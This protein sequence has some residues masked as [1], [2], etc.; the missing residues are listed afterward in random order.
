MTSTPYGCSSQLCVTVANSRKGRGQWRDD[1]VRCAEETCQKVV[2]DSP[3]EG[4][5]SP[6]ARDVEGNELAHDD[7][8]SFGT[9]RR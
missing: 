4:A 8:E 5:G 2:L 1:G 6:V 9:G 7:V 3:A